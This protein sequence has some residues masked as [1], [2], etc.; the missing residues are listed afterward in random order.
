[1]KRM[2]IFPLLFRASAGQ[3]QPVCELTAGAKPASVTPH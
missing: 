3:R 1:M 2:K